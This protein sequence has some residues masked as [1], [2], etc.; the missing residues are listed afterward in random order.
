MYITRKIERTIL[1]YIHSPEIIAIVGPRQS[2]KTTLL[3]HIYDGLGSKAI[4]LTFEDNKLLNLF[5]QNIDIFIRDYIK[6]YDYIFIDEFHYAK[7]GG[8]LL[9]YIIDTNKKKIFV[10]GSSTIELSVQTVKHLV[11][12]IFVF[13][14]FQ[15]DFE[16]FLIAKKPKLVN[17]YR[18]FKMDIND[19]AARDINQPTE[20]VMGKLKSNY[21]EY[22]VF[23]GYPRVVLSKKIEE[24][25]I[26]LKNIY[27][28]YFLR[29][30]KDILGLVDDYKMAQMI[31]ALALQIG[32]LIEYG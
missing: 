31:K 15:F 1:K 18:K 24:K 26:V 20:H 29:E 22:A 2:G 17:E 6:P 3:R 25:K 21:E 10:S 9:K 4:F 8:K 27:N 16:E 13:N 28:T 11:G 23:G 5:V 12:R 7:K 19:L 32:G 14:L 30:V